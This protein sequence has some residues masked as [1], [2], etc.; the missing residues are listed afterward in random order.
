MFRLFDIVFPS[1]SLVP[2]PE[3]AAD[4]PVFNP[5]VHHP[6][7]ANRP[8]LGVIWPVPPSISRILSGLL[9]DFGLGDQLR[10]VCQWTAYQGEA[11]CDGP[12]S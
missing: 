1:F 7:T 9:P 2:V 4:R 6:R 11:R 10:P 8:S 12:R 5:T 3:R